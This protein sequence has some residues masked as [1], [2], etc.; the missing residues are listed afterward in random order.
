M[1]KE[2]TVKVTTDNK[3]E[4]VDVDF[5]SYS[6]IYEAVGDR[7]KILNTMTSRN[8]FRTLGWDDRT[9]ILT[10]E[11]G[12]LKKLPYNHFASLM[13][14]GMILG[15][16]VLAKKIANDILGVNDPE[17]LRDKLLEDF[18]FLREG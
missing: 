2:K 3:I 17:G 14:P 4:I 1:E 6:T 12:E 18:K 9:I 15:D 16:V 11:F 8:Y 13:G 10:D 7:F 5:G